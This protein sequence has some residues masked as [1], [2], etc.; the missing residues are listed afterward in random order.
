MSTQYD[1]VIIDSPPVGVVADAVVVG[2]HVDGVLV[3]LKAAKTS[4]DAARQ[5][6]KQLH[7]VNAPIF[8]AVL[9]DLDLEDQ[10]YGQYA[11]YYRYGY[12]YGDQASTKATGV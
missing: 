7:D 12:Y 1:R 2:T 4:R 8:G 6:V 9:N 5:A 3:V 11:Y 10:K